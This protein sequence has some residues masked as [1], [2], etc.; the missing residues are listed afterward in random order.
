MKALENKFAFRLAGYLGPIQTE[1]FINCNAIRNFQYQYDAPPNITTIHSI[2][3]ARQRS[4][5][6]G[7]PTFVPDSSRKIAYEVIEEMLT[8]EGKNGRQCLLRSI[9]EVAETPVNHNGLVGELLQLFFTPGAHEKLHEDY[10]L[11]RKAGLNNVNC[12]KLYPKCP[13]GHG[14]LDSVSLIKEYGFD[15]WI[16]F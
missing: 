3:P 11:A 13:F 12:E 7:E 4:F 16:A 8:K 10:R 15:K 6:S 5:G 2:V 9:C 14:M 1:A